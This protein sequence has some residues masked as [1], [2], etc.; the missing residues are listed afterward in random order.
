M[1]S[2]ARAPKWLA[3]RVSGT[4][5]PSL[6]LLETKHSSLGCT[7]QDALGNAQVIHTGCGCPLCCCGCAPD[8]NQSRFVLLGMR[9]E[10]PERVT[11][12]VTVLPF[13]FLSKGHILQ[14]RQFAHSPFLF[15]PTATPQAGQFVVYLSGKCIANRV[16]AFLLVAPKLSGEGPLRDSGK[17][18][19]P[20]K[21]V[22]DSA[23]KASS[24][25]TRGPLS[26]CG[27]GHESGETLRRK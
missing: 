14:V 11:T 15:P 27:N 12:K 19:P 5:L 25:E 13:L 21:A 16:S 22:P 1:G 2:G 17:R 10:F 23:E 9:S 24:R 18:P 6:F 8:M 20:A 3:S 7:R 26:K 4:S